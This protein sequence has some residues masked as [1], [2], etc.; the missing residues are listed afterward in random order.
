MLAVA[1]LF[2]LVADIDSGNVRVGVVI[3]STDV[4]VQFHLDQF[5]TKSEIVAAINAV[6]YIT[7]QTNTADALVTMR[8]SMFNIQTGDRPGVRNAAVVITDGV[9]NINFE[10]TVPEAEAARADGILS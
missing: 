1:T 10:R 3:Y 6:P 4:H 8:T 5:T 7:G 9:S 2:L